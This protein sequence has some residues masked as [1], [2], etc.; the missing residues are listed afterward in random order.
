M[1][2]S[3][4]VAAELLALVTTA[5][6]QAVASMNPY[7]GGQQHRPGTMR[8]ARGATPSALELLTERVGRLSDEERV[9]LRGLVVKMR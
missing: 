4:T 6:A 1:A 3:V 8:T 7:P 9:V 5:Q 2:E